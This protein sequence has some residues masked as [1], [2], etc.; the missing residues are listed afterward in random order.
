MYHIRHRTSVASFFARRAS[1]LSS[2][3]KSEGSLSPDLELFLSLAASRGRAPSK[4]AGRAARDAAELGVALRLAP[5][6]RDKLVVP[7]ARKCV[8][9]ARQRALLRTPGLL[10]ELDMPSS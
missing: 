6:L 7:L 4:H 10:W 8:D 1:A 5:A 9:G 3:E 2:K